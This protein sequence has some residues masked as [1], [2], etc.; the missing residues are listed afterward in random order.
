MDR[1]IPFVHL[2]HNASTPLHPAVA[3]A[4]ARALRG[5]AANPSSVHALG[6]SARA[7]LERAREQVA[8]LIGARADEIVFTS[9][10]TEA[11]A[12]ALTGAL[13]EPHGR[14]ALVSAVEHPSVLEP[15]AALA[16]RGLRVESV[17]VEGSGRLDPGAVVAALGSGA[18][19]VS[20]QLAN[21]ETGVVQPVA[22]IAAAMAPRAALL[23]VDAS[24]A[25]GRMPVDV[26]A[27]GADLLTAS[28][29]KMNAPPGIG[30]LFV[31]REIALAPLLRG[32]PQ[33]R[34][35]RAGMPNLVG[36]IGLG[37]ACEIQRREG[38]ARAAAWQALRDRLWDGARAKVPGVTRTGDGVETLPNV[39]HVVFAGASGEALLAA[40]D[41]EGVAVSTGAACSSGSSEP[42]P[43]LLAMGEPVERAR[44]AIRFSVGQ[45]V[46][47]AQIDHVLALLPDLVARVRAAEQP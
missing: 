15:L 30:F 25:L 18:D 35:R 34:G 19:L 5:H 22:E 23:H 32:G 38:A 11:N 3:E 4:C 21:H 13:A 33:E 6:S 46:D 8:D 43:V 40:L 17:S 24:Q 12:L 45:G 41:L 29:H 10:A 37:V 20:L 42:S 9:G 47:A 26:G 44:C 16:R 39:L 2:D 31:R 36:A 7:A 27:L 28:G 14:R 1:R